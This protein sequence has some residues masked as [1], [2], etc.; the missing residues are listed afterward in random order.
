MVL[1]RSLCVYVLCCVLLPGSGSDFSLDLIVVW[2]KN[3]RRKSA[4]PVNSL[5]FIAMD[6]GDE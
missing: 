4:W 6:M 3:E 5:A 1:W 2:L